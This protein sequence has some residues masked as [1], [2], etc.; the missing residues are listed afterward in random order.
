MTRREAAPRQR[1]SRK[2]PHG[3]SSWIQDS[4]SRGEKK[5]ITPQQRWRL[6]E[7]AAYYRA[8]SRGFVGEQL[9]DDWAAAEAEIDERYE[10]DLD[11][12]IRERDAGRLVEQLAKA[13]SGPRFGSINVRGVL[14]A[15]HKNL[16]ALALA[17]E[18]AIEG[19][20][21]LLIVQ[22]RILKQVL[23]DA[24]D[25]IKALAEST[26]PSELIAKQEALLHSAQARAVGQMREVADLVARNQA[27]AMN[28]VRE[29]MQTHFLALNDRLKE[30]KPKG[31]R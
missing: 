13:F 25:S 3:P 26:A 14:E 6:I 21:L 30:I 5:R 20:H 18:Q 11:E 17:N 7:E 15:Q 29:R 12:T 16:E 19:V 8:Q 23:Q 10:I 9:A 1:D 24:A 27:R 28:T 2:K 4:P 31:P 22:A